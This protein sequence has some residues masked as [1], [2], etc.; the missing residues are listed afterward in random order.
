[1]TKKDNPDN[2]SKAQKRD[3]AKVT[4]T[5]PAADGPRVKPV[6]PPRSATRKGHW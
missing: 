2:A 6:Q 4:G 3:G 1:M 5:K